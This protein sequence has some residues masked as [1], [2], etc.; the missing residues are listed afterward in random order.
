MRAWTLEL[1]RRGILVSVRRFGCL[2]KRLRTLNSRTDDGF[3]IMS[4]VLVGCKALGT[5]GGGNR[6]FDD[7][8]SAGHRSARSVYLW[9]AYAGLSIDK[10]RS[11]IGEVQMVDTFRGLKGLK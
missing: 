5:M 8:R 6:R 9:H 11:G 2:L 1:V 4:S 7:R 10:Y 3:D